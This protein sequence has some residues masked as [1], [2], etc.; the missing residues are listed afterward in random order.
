MRLSGLKVLAGVFTTQAVSRGGKLCTHGA[1]MNGAGPGVDV[2]RRGLRHCGTVSTVGCVVAA[3]AAEAPDPT[4]IGM[5]AVSDRFFSRD[6]PQ[7]SRDSAN[8]YWNVLK[9]CLV[10]SD[11]KSHFRTEVR[12]YPNKVPT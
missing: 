8:I 6:L 2:G 5:M 7:I 12:F 10:F 9:C 11:P 3:V 4:A 1:R